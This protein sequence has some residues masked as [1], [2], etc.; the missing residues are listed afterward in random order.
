MGALTTTPINLANSRLAIYS[1]LDDDGTRWASG[2][3]DTVLD[4]ST[5]VDRAIKFS[6]FQAVRFYS[7][8]GGQNLNI[9]KEFTTDSN[10]QVEMKGASGANLTE[11]TPLLIQSVSLKDGNYYVMAKASR[12]DEVQ[13]RLNTARTIRVNYISEP[14]MDSVSGNFQFLG[15]VNLEIPEIEALFIQY[16]V[17]SLL[18]R[19]NEQNLA[20]GDSIFQAEKAVQDIVN[21]PLATSFPRHGE[22]QL[23]Y[24]KYE[25]SFI[26]YDDTSS[27]EN[28][29]QIHAPMYSFFDV[30][31]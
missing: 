19:D 18:P 3:S 8:S 27:K 31:I 12:P 22:S 24:R 6:L 2:S 14:S 7:N 21:V 25:W 26:R 23:L 4:M 15:G 5:P 29:I 11:D 20:L 16:A 28:V 1:L 13:S 10:G 9:Q 17:R 30:V